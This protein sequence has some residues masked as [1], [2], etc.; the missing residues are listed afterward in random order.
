[1]KPV[2]ITD[3][4]LRDAHQSLWATRMKT[5]DMLPILAELDQVGYHSL[6]VWGGATFDVCLRFLGEDP[7]ERLRTIKQH[8]KKTPLQM[9]LRGQSL[10]GYQHYPDDVVREFVQ[11]SVKNGIDI[12][13]IF[14]ALND[15][16][17]MI[18]PMEAAKAAGAHVQAS[19]VYTIS[20]VHT[21]EHYLE[22]AKALV[23]LGA[24]SICIKDMAGLL[25]PQRGHKL[26]RLLKEEL[27]VMVQLHT[28]YI[29]GMGTIAYLKAAEAGVDVIDTASVPLAFG[30][31]QPPVELVVRALQEFEFAP[32]MNIPQ[33]FTIANYFEDLRKS[34]G[35]ERGITRIS[36]MRVF[37][38]QVPGGMISNLVS[39]LEEQKALNRINEVLD[40][41][42][43]V[44]AE[45]GYPPLVTPTSQIVGTQAVLNVLSGARY[46][47]VPAEVKAYV[48]GLYGRPP[49][50]VDP[51]IQKLIIGDEEV[52]TIRPADKL[53]P[54]LKKAEQESKEFALSREDVLSYALFPQ[55]AKKFFI[56]R[57]KGVTVAA[58]SP[59]V[60]V[61]KEDSKMDLKEIKELIKLIGDTDI[62]ELNLES[63][64]V[65]VAIKKGSTAVPAMAL[66]VMGGTAT[67]VS[68]QPASTVV[69]APVVKASPE[70]QNPAEAPKKN[71]QY[72][73]APMVGTF[74][75][76]PAPDAPSFVELGQ[77]VKESQTVCIIEAM[78]LMNEIEAEIS[79][80]IVEILVENGQ[81]V[82]FGQPLF[83]VE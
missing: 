4:T 8:V 5:E 77:M 62:T 76:S 43:S 66:P 54:G 39:Q 52:L 20:P 81:P 28:H 11:L 67:E 18:V 49:A 21:L 55:V 50:P 1:M 33:L 12:I 25:T 56:E 36:D 63:Q 57:E 27:G 15:V 16:R 6:E 9:L 51:E 58:K 2:K 13:R 44:R 37:E 80:R 71:L 10:V 42:P 70:I 40:E 23:D 61:S 41:I 78:K 48:R 82:E 29:G 19:V 35:F 46:K 79:G 45:L 64:G 26:V 31:S 7:W 32:E 38:H 17:N 22:T 34:R 30:A 3:T 65:K 72:I 75:R 59:S 53:E 60:P 68:L 73:K 47:L 74:Y 83:A 14:D 24:D 69:G